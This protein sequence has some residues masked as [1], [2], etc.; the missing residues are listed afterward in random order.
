MCREIQAYQQLSSKYIP[1]TCFC[2]TCLY[3]FNT[4]KIVPDYALESE[5]ANFILLEHALKSAANIL[6]GKEWHDN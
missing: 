3:P 5:I 1:K 2:R 6:V 4:Y